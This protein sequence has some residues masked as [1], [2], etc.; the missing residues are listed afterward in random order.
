MPEPPPPCGILPFDI[1][2]ENHRTTQASS[3]CFA[4]AVELQPASSVRICEPEGLLAVAAAP[5]YC[6]CNIVNTGCFKRG[7]LGVQLL[8]IVKHD[9]Q[10]LTANPRYV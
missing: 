4:V 5:Y 2:G 6:Y 1:S 9:E 3:A 7:L 8:C 10:G